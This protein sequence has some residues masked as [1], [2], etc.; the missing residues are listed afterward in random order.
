MPMRLS[1]TSAFYLQAS[2]ILFFLAGSSAPTPLYALY[3][4]EWGF[5][6]ITVTVIFG[7]YALAVLAALLTVGSLSDYVGRRPV[8][9]VATLL[10]A[11]AMWVFATAH[12]VHAL[13]GARIIQ[14]LAT[15]GAASAIGAGMLDIDRAKGTIANAVGPMLGTATGGITSGLLVQ[16]LPAPTV[17]IYLVFGVIFVA[18]AVGVVLMPESVT[19]RAGA[20]ASLKPQFRLPRELRRPMLLATPVLVGTWAL[21]GFYGSLGPALLRRMSHSTSLVLGGLTLFVLAGSAATTVFFARRLRPN[22]L[23]GLGMVALLLG[24]GLT[25]LAISIESLPLFFLGCLV[26][27][28]GFGAGFQGAIRSVLLLASPLERAGVLSVLYVVAYL[29]MGLPAVLGGVRAV[30]GGGVIHTAREYGLAVMALAT[31]ALVGA[32]RQRALENAGAPQLAVEP[33]SR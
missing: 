1:K 31:L 12:G 23:T 28:S 22:T 26:A 10:Q 25:L 21:V 11:A 19:P 3:Q 17:L 4:A 5:S 18:Q 8:L 16:Y 9:V 13:I 15:G 29:A 24:T 14:G 20:L 2:I 6:P 27:G 32:L 33:A 30:Y 7:I